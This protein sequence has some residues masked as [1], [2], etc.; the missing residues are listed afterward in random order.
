MARQWIARKSAKSRK[1]SNPGG[2]RLPCSSK[3]FCAVGQSAC[4]TRANWGT[5][6]G[7]GYRCRVTTELHHIYRETAHWSES[8]AFPSRL[9]FSFVEECG[10]DPHRAGRRVND[11][12]PLVLAEVD[13]A[14]QP[15]Q[16]TFPASS[17][18]QGVSRAMEESVADT[19]WGTRMVSVTDPDGRTYNFDPRSDQS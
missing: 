18:I 8:V 10:S 7:C 16:A 5:G 13:P 6:R 12:A 19:H 17:D 15:S 3:D 14:S 1:L 2:P 4:T 9:G 11:A